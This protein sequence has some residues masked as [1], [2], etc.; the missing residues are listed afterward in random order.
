VERV[1]L[2]TKCEGNKRFC[3]NLAVLLGG[4]LLFCS[5]VT[6]EVDYE[7]LKK[8]VV[9]IT[10]PNETGAGIIVGVESGVTLIVTALHVI[11]DAKD[12]QIEFRGKQ[13]P[14]V[15]RRFEKHHEVLDLAVVVVDAPE[16]KSIVQDLQDFSLGNV[17]TLQLGAEVSAIGHPTGNDWQVAVLANRIQALR[18]P[19]DS[20]LFRFTNL[21]IDRGNS[22][23]PVF[24]SRGNLIGMV[25]RVVP[26]GHT[27]A[28]KSLKS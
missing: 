6:A 12:I 19:D 17:E 13:Q 1:K 27:V 18:D 25:T 20:R 22:G 9:K 4:V 8:G 23:G 7:T 10:T 14:F 3:Y 11:A 26:P 21:S 16:A 5:P 28:V 2:Q 15:G 24:D